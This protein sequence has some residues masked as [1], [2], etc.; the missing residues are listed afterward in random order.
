MRFHPRAC[1]EPLP[2]RFV[3]QIA[4]ATEASANKPTMAAFS[5]GESSVQHLFVKATHL[6]RTK[7]ITNPTTTTAPMIPT[8]SSQLIDGSFSKLAMME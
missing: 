4:S 3:A 2:H 8:I 1:S 6:L 5:T 7:K